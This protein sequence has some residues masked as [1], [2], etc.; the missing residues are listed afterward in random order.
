MKRITK[1]IKIIVLFSILVLLFSSVPFTASASLDISATEAADLALFYYCL[2]APTNDLITLDNYTATPL[3]DT[4]GNITYYCIDFFNDGEGKGYVVIGEN[5]NNLQCTEMNHEGNSPFYLSALED[6]ETIYYNP[7]EVYT[8]DTNTDIYL[9]VENQAISI[10]AVDGTLIS[11]NVNKNSQTLAA[12]SITFPEDDLVP[13]SQHP[14]DYMRGKGFTNV[15]ASSV[16]GSIETAMTNAGCFVPMYDLSEEPKYFVTTGRE[17]ANQGHCALT[18]ITNILMYW[19]TICCPN[20]PSSY[21]ALFAEVFEVAV[22]DYYFDPDDSLFDWIDSGLNHSYVDDVM[23]ETNS[24][25]AYNGRVMTNTDASWTFLKLYI[26]SSW[27]IYFRVSH[28]L[29]NASLIT[30]QHAYIIFG[31]NTINGYYQGNL[32]SYN[33][34]KLY[35]VRPSYQGGGKFYICWDAIVSQ[36]N[37]SNNFSST[38]YAFCP[39]R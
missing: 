25:H 38:M 2:N 11:G 27:P 34:A 12:A 29:S 3:Y 28:N 19:R 4:D 35:D 6:K 30:S 22:D 23:L 13:F 5:L 9:D 15:T 26:D 14:L 1:N 17:L 8:L 32:H 36:V 37:F 20:Y 7:F 10:D 33:F 31:Y 16:Y 39:Y 18:A 24:N 21:D